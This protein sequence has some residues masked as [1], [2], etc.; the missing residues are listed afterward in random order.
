MSLKV[1]S[2]KTV[3]FIPGALCSEGI[4][5]DQVA[6]ISPHF[7][8]L[9]IDTMRSKT[10]SEMAETL[11]AHAPPRFAMVGISM[12]GY[13]ALE[14]LRIAPD[15]VWG[16]V[17]ISTSA[18]AEMPPQSEERKRWVERIESGR[19]EDSVNEIVDACV[20]N[21]STSNDARRCFSEMVKSQS[22]DTFSRQMTA[23]A[24][25]PDFQ[26]S[27]KDIRCP[28]LLIGG[29]DDSEFFKN[30]VQEISESVI[31]SEILISPNCGHLPT[32]ESASS[33]TKA[34][35]QFLLKAAKCEF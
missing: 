8:A 12:G 7:S 6:G 5:S 11:L 3:V 34:I 21:K 16:A 31:G 23:C 15:R 10:I 17:L 24:T 30:G 22:V 33:T 28:V 4:F 32:I 13:V 1:N 19:Y 26:E 25:R 27:L 20:S 35:K 2:K 9:F 18:R 14:V 29:G